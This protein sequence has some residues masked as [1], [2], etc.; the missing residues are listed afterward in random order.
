MTARR[1]PKWARRLAQAGTK[2]SKALLREIVASG[3]DARDVIEG[4][5]SGEREDIAPADDATWVRAQCVSMILLCDMF[6]DERTIDLLVGVASDGGPVTA[7][8]AADELVRLGPAALPKLLPLFERDRGW[9]PMLASFGDPSLLPTFSA[10]L[11]AHVWAEDLS[12]DC[13]DDVFDLAEAIEDLGGALTPA[14]AEMVERATRRRRRFLREQG[15]DPDDPEDVEVAEYEFETRGAVGGEPDDAALDDALE[16]AL[17][18]DLDD[19]ADESDADFG[20]GDEIDEALA[21]DA[22][23]R[24]IPSRVIED[25]PSPPPRDGRS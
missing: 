17:D 1:D 7:E 13:D 20:E 25:D 2:P 10:A 14:Q 19:A 15:Y 16:D 4:I 23:R 9:A 8:I 11:D 22:D 24:G 3:E 21:D 12:Y 18:D 5:A 6:P